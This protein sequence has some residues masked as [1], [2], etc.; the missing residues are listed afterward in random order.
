LP[1]VLL[2]DPAHILYVTLDEAFSK[3]RY[4]SNL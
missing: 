3:F 4:S 2:A 1:Q